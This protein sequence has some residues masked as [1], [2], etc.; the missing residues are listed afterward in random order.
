[1]SNSIDGRSVTS[2]LA[3]IL[4]AFGGVDAQT[5]SEIARAAQLPMST[6]HRLTQELTTWGLLERTSDRS[7]RVGGA[8]TAIAGRSRE[9][10]KPCEKGRRVISDL[11][12]AT[13]LT[14]RLGVLSGHRLRYL[15]KTPDGRPTPARFEPKALPVHATA[16]GKVLL[17]FAPSAVFGAIVNGPLPRF[18]PSTLTSEIEL[19][20]AVSAIRLTQ[21]ATSHKEIG[22]NASA[23]AVPVFA[24]GGVAVAALEVV[25]EDDVNQL[26]Q[27]RAAVV[28]AGR[29]L[30]Y[31]LCAQGS[32]H[33]AGAL[34]MRAWTG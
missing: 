5:L 26:G 21:V 32:G 29:A 7:Y 24:G 9:A 19:R 2:K 28:F 6:A 14:A 22:P 27:A 12:A 23:L 3:T 33:P 16:M 25:T 15:E 31:E 1:M 17:A 30:S 20:Q 11:A 34:G 4:Q 10:P 8:L 13:R 18:T